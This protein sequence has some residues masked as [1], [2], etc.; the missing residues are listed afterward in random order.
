MIGLEQPKIYK[1]KFHKAAALFTD[2]TITYPAEGSVSPPSGNAKMPSPASEMLHERISRIIRDN[3]VIV[4]TVEPQFSK[5]FLQRQNSREKDNGSPKSEV[6]TRKLSD[7]KSKLAIALQKAD[8]RSDCSNSHSYPK[9]NSENATYQPLNLTKKPTVSSGGS[10]I[11]EIL[12]ASRES[13]ARPERMAQLLNTIQAQ[14]SQYQLQDHERDSDVGPLLGK[15]PL[16]DSPTIK[17]RRVQSTVVPPDLRCIPS[18]SSAHR[19]LSTSSLPSTLRSLEEL[20]RHPMKQ[21]SGHMVGGELKILDASDSRTKRSD[22]PCEG[23]DG[24]V[25]TVAKT[26]HASGGTLVSCSQPAFHMANILSPDTSGLSLAPNVVT[27]NLT[28]PG[29]PAPQIGVLT[30][31]HGERSIPFVPGIPGPQSLLS[32]PRRRDPK[33][34]LSSTVSNHMTSSSSATTLQVPNSVP[35][36]EISSPPPEEKTVPRKFLRPTSLPL[37]PGSF[38]PKRLHQG[39]TPTVLSLVSPETPRPKKSY[40]QLFL[41]GHAYTYLGLKCSTRSY[42]CTLSRPQPMYVMQ[43]PQHSRLSMYSNWKVHPQTDSLGLTPGQS[44]GLYDSRYRTDGYSTASSINRDKTGVLVHSSGWRS[45]IPQ[46]VCMLYK[47]V[48]TIY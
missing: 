15:T 16:I 30:I 12:I 44:M 3:Q 14:P 23:E 20:S 21:P 10:V 1:P 36:V 26:L 6:E 39:T 27:P 34:S 48:K 28:V 32:E 37:K 45:T 4:E 38:T 9:V 33:P 8:H 18:A 46:E 13:E 31:M 47:R 25:V 7:T 35:K 40:G 41:N 2:P 5:K 22:V 43:S 19:R 42:Y 24:R 17:K 11:K 29:A